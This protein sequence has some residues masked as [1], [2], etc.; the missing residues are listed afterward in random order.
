MVLKLDDEEEDDDNE[1]QHLQLINFM[2]NK[3]K[4][5][6]FK[7]LFLWNASLT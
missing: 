6:S 1:R 5:R 2:M 4:N 3:V 7:L